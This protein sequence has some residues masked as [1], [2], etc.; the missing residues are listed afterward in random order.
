VLEALA[1]A[2]ELA[3]RVARRG[4]VVERLARLIGIAPF[5]DDARRRSACRR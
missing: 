3:A 4:D 5:V 1:R 2:G